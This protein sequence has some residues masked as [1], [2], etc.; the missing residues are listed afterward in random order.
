MAEALFGDDDDEDDFWIEDPYAEADDLAEH[1]MH[2]PVLVNYDP[3]FEIGTDWSDWEYYSDDFYDSDSPKRKRRKLEDADN[4]PKTPIHGKKQR[5]S[6]T[7]G[8][9]PALSLGLPAGYNG[10]QEQSPASVVVWKTR[11][12]LPEPPILKDGQQEKVSILK[13]WK[14][15]FKL[16]LQNTMTTNPA[17]NGSQ[18]AVAVVIQQ[19]SDSQHGSKRSTIP[20]DRRHRA[21]PS[22]P[23]PRSS[24][25]QTQ[26]GTRSSLA[27]SE[28]V[29]ASPSQPRQTRKRKASTSPQS[30]IRGGASKR[31]KSSADASVPSRSLRKAGGGKQSKAS[32]LKAVAQSDD[33][34]GESEDKTLRPID[35]NGSDSQHGRTGLRS[36]KRKNEEFEELSELDTKRVKSKKEGAKDTTSKSRPKAEEGARRSTRRK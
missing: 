14:E 33:D 24:L 13:D 4:G 16:P 23:S 30:S 31:A 11:E 2:S 19:D 25:S 36:K 29:D 8:E 21:L 27:D 10:G 9:I 32:K 12:A 7:L 1:T 3:A 6:K 22:R 5:K 20:Q 28:A 18:R 15:R 34:D 26:T 35:Q 17:T